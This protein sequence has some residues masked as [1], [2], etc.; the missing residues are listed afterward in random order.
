M[1]DAVKLAC[2]MG[3]SPNPKYFVNKLITLPGNRTIIHIS[4]K[5]LKISQ[6]SD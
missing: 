2:Y 3:L 4:G 1:Q 6:R 5:L